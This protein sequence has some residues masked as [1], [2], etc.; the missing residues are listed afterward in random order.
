MGCAAAHIVIYTK[1]RGS[2]RQK[3]NSPAAGLLGGGSFCRRLP[4][5]ICYQQGFPLEL[6]W[7]APLQL[8]LLRG[9]FTSFLHRFCLRI[10][11]LNTSGSAL[12]VSLTPLVNFTQKKLYVVLCMERS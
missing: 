4:G 5:G 11:A 7:A 6:A 1:Q 10:A 9:G 3:L 12:L 2:G 8:S